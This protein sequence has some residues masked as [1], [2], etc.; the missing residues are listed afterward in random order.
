PDR[1]RAIENELARDEF[2]NLK[3]E[4]AKPVSRAAL[5]LAHAPEH[6]AH[7]YEFER[8]QE[9]IMLDADTCMGPHSLDAALHA[10]GAALRAA[11]AVIAGEAQNAFCAVR[12]PGHH[13]ERD[14]AMG[15]C[16]FNNAAVAAKHAQRTHDLRKIAIVDFDVHHG[17]G[18]QDIF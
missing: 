16:L 11:D 15:F 2:K 14:K 18:T 5:A 13:A 10:V 17:N 7:V 6:I 12:P 8:T 9:L 3:R 1:L 4:Q